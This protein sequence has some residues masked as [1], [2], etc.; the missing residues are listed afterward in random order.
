MEQHDLGRGNVFYAFGVR[1]PVRHDVAQG[2]FAN[3]AGSRQRKYHPLAQFG[4][5]LQRDLRVL[6]I[7][8]DARMTADART[9]R[10]I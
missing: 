3:P 8:G 9:E 2:N 7:V 1:E 6:R 4:Q 10:A 5:D